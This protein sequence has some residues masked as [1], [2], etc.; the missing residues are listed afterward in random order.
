[1]TNRPARNP[2]RSRVK[3]FGAVGH[4]RTRVATCADEGAGEDEHEQPENQR[5]HGC[6]GSG[7]ERR[8]ERRHDLEEVA[9][10]AVVGDFED[11]RVRDPC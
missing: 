11:G 2:R 5:L 1:M 9:D 8:E 4:R 7:F 6:Q 3:V 10:D